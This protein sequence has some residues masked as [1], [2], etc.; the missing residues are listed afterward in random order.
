MS[1]L[2][3]TQRSDILKNFKTSQ[4]T[5]EAIADFQLVEDKKVITLAN[6]LYRIIE[7]E[8]DEMFVKM[9]DIDDRARLPES[10]KVHTGREDKIHFSYEM[11]RDRYSIKAFISLDDPIH[12]T[13]QFNEE[14]TKVLAPGLCYCA[15]PRSDFIK[16][17]D[18]LL[19]EDYPD[20]CILIETELFTCGN[21]LARNN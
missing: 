7:T 16:K 2:N 6:E 14:Q 21:A 15:I 8:V 3:A 4:Q 1:Q 11:V 12:F 9:V 13:V 10:F 18:D 5:L 19:T 20:I 17:M